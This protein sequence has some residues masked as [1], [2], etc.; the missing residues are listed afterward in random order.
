MTCH[1]SGFRLFLSKPDHIKKF[2]LMKFPSQTSVMMLIAVFLFSCRAPQQ[3]LKPSA[4]FS[5]LYIS[6]DMRSIDEG[7]FQDS[8]TYKVNRF[9]HA[10]NSEI[11][12]FK[13]ALSE[14]KE[15][16]HIKIHFIRTGFVSKKKSWIATGISV[17]GIGTASTLIATGFLVPF[18]WVYFPAAKCRIMPVISSD[19]T[20]I[21]VHQQVTI[22]SGGLFRSMSKQYSNQSTKIIKYLVEMVLQMET[23][24]TR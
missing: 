11:H 20:D 16:P 1:K 4:K 2:S 23:E 21:P 5:T 6:L 10:Y 9:I 22:S 8:I 24:Y 15:T 12:P 18:G 3:V 17:A 14:G 19:I 13:L 7:N